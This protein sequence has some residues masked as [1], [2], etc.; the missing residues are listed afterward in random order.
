MIIFVTVVIILVYSEEKTVHMNFQPHKNLEEEEG[1]SLCFGEA[2]V[3]DIDG[4]K[5]I[6][7]WMTTTSEKFQ[8]TGCKAGEV[9]ELSQSEGCKFGVSSYTFEPYGL[10]TKC[11]LCCDTAPVDEDVAK[12]QVDIALL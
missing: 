8:R 11:Y 4:L 12:N 10:S 1:S 3:T 5:K 2:E 6:C 7:T 9:C